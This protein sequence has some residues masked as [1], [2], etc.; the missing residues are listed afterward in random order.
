MVHL[1]DEDFK[2]LLKKRKHALVMFYAPWCGHC[3]KAKPEYMAAAEQFAD[4]KKTMFAA[5]DCTKHKSVCGLYEVTGYPT[6]KYFS[7][8]K[9][10]SPFTGARDEQGFASFMADPSSFVRDEL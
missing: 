6:F 3:K 1:S 7:F 8:G 5:V 9:K 10:A 2:P 4:D